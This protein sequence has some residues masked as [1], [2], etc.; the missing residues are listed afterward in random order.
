MTKPLKIAPDA[1]LKDL[2]G[3]YD[4]HKVHS[5]AKAAQIVAEFD[6]VVALLET[7]PLIFH[8]R[9]SGWRIY[10]FNSGTYLLYYIEL[11]TMWLV[12]GVFHAR[13]SPTWISEQ[14][15]GRP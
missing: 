10:P 14:L 12:S 2:Q 5:V 4:Y 11:E 15:S 8:E 13:R 7:N 9:A 3:I 1:I 6:R